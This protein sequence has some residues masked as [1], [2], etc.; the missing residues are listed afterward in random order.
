[1]S[2][3]DSAALSPLIRKRRAASIGWPCH[4]S[5]SPSVTTLPHLYTPLQS[6]QH[7]ATLPL[8][9]MESS[10]NGL[11]HLAT[12][13]RLRGADPFPQWLLSVACTPPLAVVISCTRM[14]LRALLPYRL[15]GL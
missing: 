9:R 6:L 15:C 4:I 12:R 1:M 7:I 11:A 5:S 13:G 10:R 14:N 2:Q 8:Y 3:G